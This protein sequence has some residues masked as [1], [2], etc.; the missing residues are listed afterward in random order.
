MKKGMYAQNTRS[1]Y[2]REKITTNY[3]YFES[4]YPILQ[5]KQNQRYFGVKGRCRIQLKLK[6]I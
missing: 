6:H 4:K 3:H 2:K 5:H 1:K